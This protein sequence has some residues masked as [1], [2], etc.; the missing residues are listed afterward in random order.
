M[1]KEYDRDSRVDVKGARE[2]SKGVLEI[3]PMEK[4]EKGFA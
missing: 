3:P 4:V 2:E 1:E